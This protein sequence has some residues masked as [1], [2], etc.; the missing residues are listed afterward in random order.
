MVAAN[1]CK[2]YQWSREGTVWWSSS[3]GFLLKGLQCFDERSVSKQN[4]L[5]RKGSTANICQRVKREIPC[6]TFLHH[7]MTCLFDAPNLCLRKLTAAHGDSENDCKVILLIMK[8]VVTFQ[9]Y[10][11]SCFFS[12]KNCIWNGFQAKSGLLLIEFCV[13]KTKLLAPIEHYSCLAFHLDKRIP[14]IIIGNLILNIFQF[15]WT[16]F[17]LFNLCW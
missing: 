7:H 11:C 9:L 4:P 17:G 5:C 3:P 8:S 13:Q 15:G 10:T 12:L 6:A 1:A 2:C 14:M 16:C